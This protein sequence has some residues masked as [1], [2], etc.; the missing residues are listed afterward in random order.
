M[1]E[2]S[3]AYKSAIVGTDRK[4]GIK[5]VIDISDPDLQYEEVT[6]DSQ[7]PFCQPEELHDKD[8]SNPPRYATLEKNRW[9]LDG[10]FDIFPDDYQVEGIGFVGNVLSGEDGTFETPVYVDLNFSQVS[11]LQACSIYFSS[12]ELDGIPVDFEVEV[13]QGG[14]AYFTEEVT[15]NT[16]AMVSFDGFTVYNPDKIRLTV[17]KWSLPGRRMRV[18]E[19]IPG[20]YEEW[21][22]DQISKFDIEQNGDFSCLTLPYGSCNISM[23]N[24]SRRFEPRRKDGIFQ[25]IE[26]RQAVDVS[27]GVRLDTGRYDYKRVGVF[28]QF[29]NG[30]NTSDNGMV[31]NWSLVDIVG[32]LANREF[33]PPDTLPT[34]LVGWIAAFVAQLGDNF[35]VRYHVDPEYAGK[36]CTASLADVQGKSCGE[37][38]RYACMATGTWPR[39]DAETGYLTA[40]PLWD[41]GNKL[42]LD[43]MSVYPRMSANTS[44]AALIFTLNDGNSTQYVVSGNQTASEQTVSINN[45]FIHSQSD[46]L[47]AARLIL[48]CY[49]GN[50][51]ETTG[52][53]NP[54]SEIGDVD[55]VWL[56]ESNATTGRRMMQGFTF[57]DGVMRGCKSKLLQADG[58]YLFEEFAVI[59][60]SGFWKAP[61]NVK[62]NQLRL[63]LGDGGQGGSRGQDGFVGGSGVLPGSGVTSSQGEKGIDGKGGKVWYGVIEINPE[64]EFEVVL[65]DGGE[66]SDTYG[67]AGAM[68]G[69]TKFGA[70]SSENGE[71]YPNG[72]TDITNGQS[73][74]RTGVEKPLDG[75]GDGGAGGDGGEPGE[76]YWKEYQYVVEGSG[77]IN[78][79]WDFIIT[80]E[81]GPGKPGVKGAKGFAMVTWDKEDA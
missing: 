26:E 62:N 71:L 75:T 8:L 31:M 38:L 61:A 14:T 69:I 64:Q 2:S 68:G 10:S 24:K 46:A 32:L 48:S 43:N 74:A 11:V 19:I 9:S 81:P 56:D 6:A 42:D 73:F 39:A 47:T 29:S 37:L 45:P 22:G 25:S 18:V 12:D 60:E 40:E 58:S 78:T 63:V 51:M 30:W 67:V 53:G 7:A 54:S 27:I 52:R 55:T 21:T 59:R 41:Q 23:D 49:G 36:S 17:T 79:G 65:G 80:K 57:T 3:E 16:S 4:I 15:G 35:A 44:I 76:G 20:V 34:T 33:I 77:V 72:Y 13:Q 66:P 1:I 5:A 50:I 70:Y 28:Y